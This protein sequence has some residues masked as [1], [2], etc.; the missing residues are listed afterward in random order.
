MGAL[1]AVEQGGVPAWS[2]S[3]LA[4]VHALLWRWPEQQGLRPPRPP[5]GFEWW[6][7]EPE[8][9]NVPGARKAEV[10]RLLSYAPY[11]QDVIFYGRPEEV[12][13]LRDRGF[14]IDFERGGLAIARFRACPAELEIAPGPRGH[15]ATILQFGWTPATEPTFSSTLPAQ[16]E[17]H[18]ARRWPVPE[19]PCGEVWF[20]VLFDYDGD[21]RLSD[22]DG[23]CM[24]ARPDGVVAA[25]ILAGG[26]E[27]I[28]CSPG[29]IVKLPGRPHP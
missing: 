7:S 4:N 26:G 13:W 25:R 27:R 10:S 23:T 21:G 6:L 17:S 2:F 8:V 18:E 1:F 9:A 16:P 24:E 15:S 5:R 29:Q 19:C 28:A 12:D 14:V 3:E 11:Y 20:R 22:G